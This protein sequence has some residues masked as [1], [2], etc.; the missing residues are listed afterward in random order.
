MSF[1]VTQSLAVARSLPL[2]DRTVWALSTTT[3]S[4]RRALTSFTGSPSSPLTI[5]VTF[6]A[7]LPGSA[8][9][10]GP[11]S[12][13]YCRPARP[14]VRQ[15]SAYCCATRLIRR[16][17]GFWLFQFTMNAIPMNR[18]STSRRGPAPAWP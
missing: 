12:A 2:P 11:E 8:P 13:S 3:F 16:I 6:S 7:T 17:S 14:P 5:H 4:G 15:A 10:P 18:T 9:M 1:Q